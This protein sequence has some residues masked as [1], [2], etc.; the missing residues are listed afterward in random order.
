MPQKIPEDSLFVMGDN[1][2]YSADSHVWGFLPIKNIIGK[3][4]MIILPPTRI[5]LLK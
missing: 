1:R 4:E 2:P 3:A 5:R